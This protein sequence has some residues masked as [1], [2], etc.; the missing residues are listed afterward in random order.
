MRADA[1]QAADQRLFKQAVAAYGGYSGLARQLRLPL[2]TVHGWHCRQSIRPGAS[3][4]SG[5]CARCATI[6]KAKARASAHPA[7]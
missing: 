6:A 7:V 3:T 5:A 2:T 1:Q 4:R